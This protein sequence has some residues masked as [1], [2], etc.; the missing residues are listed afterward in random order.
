[1]VVTPASLQ[2][3]I[4]HGEGST[5]EFKRSTGELREGLEAL[6][7]FLNTAGRRVLFGVRRNELIEDV[8][9]RR[10]FIEKRGRGT[11]KIIE[12]DALVTSVRDIIRALVRML[13]RLP[14][15][16]ILSCV[17]RAIL[18]RDDAADQIGGHREVS[19]LGSAG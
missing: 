19:C 4:S 11:Q 9:Y 16:A 7:A 2:R 8:F 6:C 17:G 10:G 5:L 3:L 18:G 12:L 13:G 1:V 14:S 15:H